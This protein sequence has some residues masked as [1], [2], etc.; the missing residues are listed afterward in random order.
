VNGELLNLR[1]KVSDISRPLPR[2]NGET[3]KA[4]IRIDSSAVETATRESPNTS[5]E[6]NVEQV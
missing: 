5:M 2:R 1:K 3:K 6:S 4:S